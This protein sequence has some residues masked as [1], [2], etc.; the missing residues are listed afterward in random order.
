MH[1]VDYLASKSHFIF[2]SVD[3]NKFDYYIIF[4]KGIF[5]N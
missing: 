1:T 2:Y 4:L 5:P 3:T